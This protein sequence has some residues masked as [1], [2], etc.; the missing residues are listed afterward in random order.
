VRQPFFDVCGG[1]EQALAGDGKQAS[2]AGIAM[3][4]E[5]LGVGKGTFHPF[6]APLVN[7]V[8]PMG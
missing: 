7:S 2:E 5:L 4:V 1:G 6:L 3:A 8:C